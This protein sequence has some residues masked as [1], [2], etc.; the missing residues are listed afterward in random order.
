MKKAICLASVFTVVFIGWCVLRIVNSVSFSLGCEAYLQRAAVANTI[1]LAKPELAT[2]IEYA[3]Q[4]GLTSG[5][6]S[7][8]LKNPTNDIGYW[9]EN[10]KAAY[11][12]LDKIP[13]D[14]SALEKTNV[15][16]KLR[17][18]LTNNSGGS[19]TNVVVPEGISIYPNNAAYF[20]VCILSLTGSFISWIWTLEIAVK[21]GYVK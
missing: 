16:M 2:A 7:I 15:L 19:D 4:N 8:F 5:I 18:S 13:S 10:L 12:E 6:V 1:E 20:W 11:D 14:A 3:E 17:E 9:Y 21:K